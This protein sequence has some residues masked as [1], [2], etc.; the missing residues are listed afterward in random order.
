MFW[1]LPIETFCTFPLVR[2][3][4]F[5]FALL[6][7]P[8]AAARLGQKPRHSL[9][10]RREIDQKTTQLVV[11]R[12]SWGEA[13]TFDDFHDLECRLHYCVNPKLASKESN[14]RSVRSLSNQGSTFT[15]GIQ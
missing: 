7:A 8:S 1:T 2:F 14:R 4:T 15:Y 3:C 13:M 12:S 10:I 9:G 5:P 11:H 6:T